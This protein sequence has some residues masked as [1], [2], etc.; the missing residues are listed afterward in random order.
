MKSLH[1]FHN[2]MKPTSRWR[3]TWYVT[4][5]QH[6]YNGYFIYLQILYITVVVYTYCLVQ[7]LNFLKDGRYIRGKMKY[8]HIQRFF[9]NRLKRQIRK[10]HQSNLKPLCVQLPSYHSSW[11][12][13]WWHGW[14]YWWGSVYTPLGT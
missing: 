7:L 6:I 10:R 1:I 4:K 8:F 3:L 5:Y 12:T 14:I 13:K 11:D 2:I 9:T